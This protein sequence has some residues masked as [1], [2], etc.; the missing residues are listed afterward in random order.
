MLKQEIEN[1]NQM[2]FFCIDEFVPKKHLLR[3]IDKA[4]NFEHIY[5]IV[6]DL[7]C[8]DS[9]RPSCDPIVLFKMVIIQHLYGIASLR[10]TVEEINMNVAYRWFLGYTMTEK[11]PHFATI[12]Y[13]RCCFFFRYEMTIHQTGECFYI[14]N[15]L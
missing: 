15:M 14:G 7:Y 8:P 1:R 6:E 12:S 4:V 2:E 11:I 13:N 3:K 9:G 5:E 10:R